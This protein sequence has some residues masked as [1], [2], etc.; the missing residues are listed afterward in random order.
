[1]TP[2]EAAAVEAGARRAGASAG[3]PHVVLLHGLGADHRAFQRFMRLLPDAW[4]VTALDLLG[5]GDAPHPERGYGLADHARYV[6]GRLAE[7]AGAGTGASELEVAVRPVLVGH[8]YG[9]ATAVAVAAE[10]PNLVRGIVLMDAIV[11]RRERADELPAPLSSAMHPARL[12]DAAAAGRERS[13]RGETATQRMMRARREGALDEVVPELFA[14]E[15]APLQ[16]WIIDTWQRMSVGVVDEFDN[17]WIRYS[18][19]VH[20]PVYVVHGDAE[21]GGGGPGPASFFTGAHV[22]RIEGAGHYL[23]A[24]HAR[25]T[26]AAVAEAVDA[27]T[28]GAGA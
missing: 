10:F 6:A 3:A 11:N 18:G 27:I 4:D 12:A 14:H 5:H 15:S 1:V 24:T 16:R 26:A 9:A 13:G 7:L 23:H 28:A 20:C 17:D 22:T 19:E 25:Q 8:S 2:G 21:M